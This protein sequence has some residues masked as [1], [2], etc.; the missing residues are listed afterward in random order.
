[1][2]R[3]YESATPDN[4]SIARME[5]DLVGGQMG[6]H[7]GLWD[8]GKWFRVEATAKSGVFHNFVDLYAGQQTTAG[9]LNGFKRR[10]ETTSVAGEINVTAIA[11]VT[12]CIAITFGYTGLWLADIGLVPDQSNNFDLATGQ[13][14][15]DVNGVSYQGGHVGIEWVY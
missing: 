13:G 11:Q 8:R 1:M 14:N 4:L 12:D 9:P 15:L 10:F 5:N 7:T 2:L 6:F 3:V